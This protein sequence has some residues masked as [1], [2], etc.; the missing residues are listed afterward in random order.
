MSSRLHDGCR[1]PKIYLSFTVFPA[2]IEVDDWWRRAQEQKKK[3]MEEL[4]AVLAELGVTPEQAL[5][6]A[7][8][9]AA[10]EKKEAEAAVAT[11]IF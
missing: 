5:A 1:V 8:A 3:E 6:N 11:G 2:C 9:K 4:N 7:K 10:A